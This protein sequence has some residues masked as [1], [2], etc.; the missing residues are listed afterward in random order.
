MT[1][2]HPPT[3]TFPPLYSRRFSPLCVSC[4]EPIVPAPGS[5]ET[6]RVVALD[7]NF[8]LKCYR[9][10]VRHFTVQ[11]FHQN[12]HGV[13]KRLLISVFV[14]QDCA[15]PLSI[16]ADE[17]GCY[18]LD[19]R[20]LCMKCHTQRAKRAAQW[21]AEAASLCLTMNQ[22][23]KAQDSLGYRFCLCNRALFSVCAQVW[24]WMC[25]VK[26]FACRFSVVFPRLCSPQC[27]SNVLHWNRLSSSFIPHLQLSNLSFCLLCELECIV[28]A[29]SMFTLKFPAELAQEQF[30][31][32]SSLMNIK[33]PF[34][35]SRLNIV[36]ST[37]YWAISI[38]R[39]SLAAL[40]LWTMLLCRHY[41]ETL[42]ELGE[43]YQEAPI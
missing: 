26:M 9:C 37:M 24:M 27:R 17:N 16:E 20:I 42:L 39:L 10:E 8:H 32:K 22:I 14:L 33:L 19:G 15:R 5:E 25:W 13:S 4:N 1:Q 31:Q 29:N 35:I 43:E 6:V 36:S 41:W 3:A 38:L 18:P 21:L 30:G 34:V 23:Q 40:S 2:R 12:I 28:C 7:K 11:T